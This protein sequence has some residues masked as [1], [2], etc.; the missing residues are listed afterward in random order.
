MKRFLS[1]LLAA[2]MMLS[3][4]A[5]AYAAESVQGLEEAY[6]NIITYAEEN[7]I[8]LDM[9][10]EDFLASYNGE[11]AAEYEQ[12]FYPVFSAANPNARSSSSSGSSKYYYNTGTTCP[13][14]ATYSKYNLLDVV[15]K[16]DI[17]FEANGGFGITGHVAI[18]EGLY[19]RGDGTNYIR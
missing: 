12:M 17:I 1:L 16:G 18:V 19:S 7:N 13:N 15:K 2:I 6:Q 3:I 14:S 5:P 8:D 4:S 9:T 11:S 10:Y